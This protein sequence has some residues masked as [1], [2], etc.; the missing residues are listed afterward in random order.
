MSKI[1][2]TNGYIPG[3]LGKI[4]GMHGSYYHKHWNF[5]FYFEALAATEMS[6]LLGR[7]DPNHDGFWLARDGDE[8]IGG[9]TI[10][11][12]NAIGEGARLRWFILDEK[13]QGRGIG[14]QLIGV[15]LAF[16]RNAGFERVYLTTFAGL[17]TARHLYEQFGFKL[18][19]EIEDNHWGTTLMEQKFELWLK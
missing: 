3:S 11:G 1:T 14:R 5:G 6:E 18:Y 2:I 8:I 15:A 10:D 4:I 19:E 13:Y 7:F 16:C 12:K 9:V 17:N